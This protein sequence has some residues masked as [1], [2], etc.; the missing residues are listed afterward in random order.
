MF[1]SLMSFIK[2]LRLKKYV[3]FDN[4]FSSNSNFSSFFL[5]S[6]FGVFLL[7]GEI[8]I[9]FASFNSIF[10]SKTKIILE[11][12]NELVLFIGNVSKSC[13]ALISFGPPFG[14]ITLAQLHKKKI[15]IYI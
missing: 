10:S 8:K 12:L 14:A 1:P 6:I 13:G 4:N 9:L 2:S 15:H 5:T 11:L 7:Y 3:V